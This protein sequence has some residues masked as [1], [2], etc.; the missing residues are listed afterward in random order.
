MVFKSPAQ[1]KA[2]MVKLKGTRKQR[3]VERHLDNGDIGSAF[4]EIMTQAGLRDK[5]A[6]GIV[7]STVFGRVPLEYLDDTTRD[8]AIKGVWNGTNKQM[9]AKN[10]ANIVINEAIAKPKPKVKKK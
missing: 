6:R 4:A 7:S 10:T 3:L 5:K 8:S 9:M 1:R 2:V